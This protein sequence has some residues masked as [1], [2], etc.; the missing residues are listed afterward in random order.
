M[1]WCSYFGQSVVRVNGEDKFS[2]KRLEISDSNV[3]F[4]I[5]VKTPFGELELKD[6]EISGYWYRRGEFKFR[7]SFTAANVTTQALYNYLSKEHQV[8]TD[9]LYY[10]LEKALYAMR[11]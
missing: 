2:V 6:E 7:N 3:G 4:S 8:V 9:F 10:L 11:F 1:D 5:L